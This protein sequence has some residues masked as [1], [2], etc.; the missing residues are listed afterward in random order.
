MDQPNLKVFDFL[1]TKAQV[2]H[3]KREFFQKK[4]LPFKLGHHQER[5]KHHVGVVLF[6]ELVSLEDEVRKLHKHLSAP[7]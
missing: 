6:G 7:H 5:G 1:D 2:V 3:Q 4:F